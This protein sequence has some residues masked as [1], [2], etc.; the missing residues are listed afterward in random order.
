[1]AC[2]S[3]LL[4][5]RLR[6]VDQASGLRVGVTV[7]TK[8]TAWL[9]RPRLAQRPTMI[10]IKNMIRHGLEDAGAGVANSRSCRADTFHFHITSIVARKS[11]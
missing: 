11:R 10:T 9:E 3:F 1:M 8:G 2:D 6:F 4:M 7:G 5:Q